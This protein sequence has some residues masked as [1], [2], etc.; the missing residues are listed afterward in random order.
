[1]G[2]SEE[3]REKTEQAASGTAV[4]AMHSHDAPK[5]RGT[6]RSRLSNGRKPGGGQIENDDR[7]HTRV[8]W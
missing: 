6:G 8:V 2:K 1:M 4:D 3:K 7:Y 5:L